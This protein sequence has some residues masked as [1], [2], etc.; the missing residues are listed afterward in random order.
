MNIG[1]GIA[2]AAIAGVMNGLFPLPMKANKAWAWENNWLP[3]SVL[4]LL[5]FPAV[6]T[7][8][9]VPQLSVAFQHVTL[10]DII[11][12]MI[13]GALVYTGSLLFGISVVYAGLTLSFALLV[14]SMNVIGI[15]VPRLLLNRSLL[16]SG[17]DWLVLAGV[18]LSTVSVVL[19]FLASKWKGGYKEGIAQAPPQRILGIYSGNARRNAFG[20][21]ARCRGDVVVTSS[22]QLGDQLWSRISRWSIECRSLP[23]SHWGS[24]PKLQLLSISAMEK[25]HRR[26]LPDT[27]SLLGDHS[28]DGNPVLSKRSSVGC[29]D[30]SVLARRLRLFRGL[31]VICRDDCPEFNGRGTLFR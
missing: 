29:R 6:I 12:T 15:L 24:N 7:W 14:G 19:G 9:S 21:T 31:G 3:F 16:G 13:C 11:A 20:I 5:L 23:D 8:Y 4:S 26:Q 1:A 18:A 17:S 10:V 28:R 30:F 2:I 27:Q 25:A 22:F